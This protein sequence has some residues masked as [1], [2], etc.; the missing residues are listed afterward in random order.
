MKI[1]V[2]NVYVQ[3]VETTGH[4]P[5]CMS[6]IYPVYDNGFKHMAGVM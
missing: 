5:G 6:Y 3:A 1:K 4:S 2:G